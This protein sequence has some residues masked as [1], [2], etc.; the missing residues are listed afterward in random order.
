MQNLSLYASLV[1][2]VCLKT[3]FDE[4]PAALSMPTK[5]TAVAKLPDSLVR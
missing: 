4:S 2:S 3:S 1:G 5:S